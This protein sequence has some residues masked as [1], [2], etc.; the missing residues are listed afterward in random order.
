MNDPFEELLE[1]GLLE[2]PADFVERVLQRLEWPPAEP[3]WRRWVRDAALAGGA[4]LGAAQLLTFALAAW[5]A[6]TAF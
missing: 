5:T 4:L 2:P 6:S 3:R 1:R